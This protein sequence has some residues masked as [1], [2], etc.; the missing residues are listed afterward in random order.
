MNKLR[1]FCFLI[2]LARCFRTAVFPIHGPGTLAAH[3]LH[4]L[5]DL[6][7]IVHL[8]GTQLYPIFGAAIPTLAPVLKG[9]VG[10]FKGTQHLQFFMATGALKLLLSKIEPTANGVAQVI[11]L[12]QQPLKIIPGAVTNIRLKQCRIIH[13]L[14]TGGGHIAVLQ[15]PVQVLLLHRDLELLGTVGQADLVVVGI[16]G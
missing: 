1:I 2:A 6:H 12:V 3:G 5:A 11:G 13:F 7:M 16:I 4:L 8:L 10:K 15:R 14:K 9:V